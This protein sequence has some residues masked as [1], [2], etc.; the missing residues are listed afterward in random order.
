MFG[1]LRGEERAR[2][3]VRS[4]VKEAWREYLPFI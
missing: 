3:G 4:E 1:E 2:R